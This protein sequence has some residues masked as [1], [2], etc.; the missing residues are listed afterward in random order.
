MPDEP[1]YNA[2]GKIFPGSQQPCHPEGA[3]LCNKRALLG[4]THIFSTHTP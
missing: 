3:A 4:R 1:F 2:V